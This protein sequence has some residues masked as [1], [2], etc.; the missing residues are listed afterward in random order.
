MCVK[1]GPEGR[2][3][4]DNSLSASG[5]ASDNDR[6]VVQCPTCRTKFRIA[7][8]KVTDRGVRVRCTSCKNVF[9]VRKPGASPADPGPGPG[10]TMDLSSLDAA[11]VARP[12]ARP[13]GRNGAAPA[14][15]SATSTARPAA[16]RSAGPSPSGARR[17]DADDLFGMAELT[18][19]APLAGGVLSRP[20]PLAP[21]KPPSRAPP[22]PM[23]NFDD[24]DLE[25][26][27]A[28]PLPSRPP[29]APRASRPPPPPRAAEPPPPPPPL[30]DLSAIGETPPPPAPRRDDGPAGANGTLGAIPIKDPFEGVSLGKPG[31][32]AIDLATEPRR[33]KLAEAIRAEP[34]RPP[35]PP[36]PEV[37]LGKELVSSALTGLVGAALAVAVVIVAALSGEK[38]AGWLGLG[39]AED[40]VA[41]GVV[42][43]LYDTASGR[44]VFYVRGQIENRGQKIRGP[45]RVTAE[46]VSDG[47]AQARAEA[48]AGTE[49]T[50]E[51][52]WALR[53][54]AD[55][56]KLTRNLEAAQ[57]ERKVKPGA[58]LP[59][60][61][62]IP[63][64]PSDL[65]RHRLHVTVESV[66]AWVTPRR[67]K[68]R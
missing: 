54:A 46:L 45:V 16:A 60:F 49:P 66:D 9:Q 37:P 28:P 41:T 58:S 38:P 63:D 51:E 65:Q 64:P 30:D 27:D 31:T 23:P 7:D 29:P 68:G 32:G 1:D 62:V 43:G 40:V 18:G 13:G 26:N 53:S 14:G 33:D 10:S 39:P 6:V 15:R 11:T 44:P 35:P 56:E 25:V 5:A 34:P 47:T 19:E 21:G 67:G 52:V 20:P 24:I 36:P 17:L 61:A 50:A 59:F 12:S 2:N 57:A 48:I 4:S 55:A 22:A 42:S 8:D 3:S